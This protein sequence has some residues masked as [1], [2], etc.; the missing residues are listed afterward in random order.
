MSSERWAKSL[1]RAD[2][3][4]LRAAGRAIRILCSEQEQRERAGVVAP[5][6]NGAGEAAAARPEPSPTGETQRRPR[7]SSPRLSIS[8]RR[9]VVVLGVLLVVSAVLALAARAATPDLTAEGPELDAVVGPK[10]LAG[11][12]VLLDERR[13]RVAPRREADRAGA[14]GRRD[15]VPAGAARGGGTRA[16]DPEAGPALRLRRAL[17]LVRRRHEGPA[18]APRSARRPSGPASHS[19][20]AGSSSR[21]RASFAAGSPS[22]SMRGAS[23]RV[24]SLPAPPSSPRPTPRAIEPVEGSRDDRPS[25]AERPIRSVHVTA[26]GWADKTLRDGVMAL[27]RNKKINAIEL[28]LKDEA[29]E[30]GWNPQVPLARQIGSAL[31]IYDLGKTVRQLHAQGVRVIGRLVC[32]RDPIHAAA[33]WKAGRRN[34]VVQTPDGSPYAGY[35]GFTNFASP[36]VR[37]YNIDVAVAAPK[38]GVDEILYDYLRRP[39]GPLTSMVFPGCAGRPRRRSWSSSQRAA[40]ARSEGPRS[41]PRSSASRPPGRPRSRRTSRRWLATST[42]SRRWSTRRTGAPAST[43][44]PI[45]TGARTRSS[46]VRLTDFVRQ[47]RGTGARVMPWLQ[48]FSLGRDYGPEEVRAQINGARDAG[49]DDFLLWDPAVTYTEDALD[50]KARRPALGV[51]TERPKDAP[52]PIRLPDPKPAPTPVAKPAPVASKQPAPGLAVE[53][54]RADP[55]RDAPHG[56]RRSRRRLRPDAGGVPCR[57]RPTSGSAGTSRSASATS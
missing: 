19:S 14:S 33:A 24:R 32:F 47:V 10:A 31:K 57:A 40:R 2:V 49:A 22:R 4:E 52:G 38:L 55:D 6:A 25:A 15:G 27:V 5:A 9:A 11:A 41:A 37:R 35:G 51:T 20:S 23:L 17:V 53:R 1:G 43:T 46:A 36:A 48:D 12:L 18:A 54:A 21:A 42:T 50:A 28:D 29:G 56:P 34:E 16:R 13:S 26:Y 7:L 3:A 39:D 45:P 8:R 44:S 30:I